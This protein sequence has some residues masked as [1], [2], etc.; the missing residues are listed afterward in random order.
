MNSADSFLDQQDV[1][2]QLSNKADLV[3]GKVP[4]GQLPDS[5]GGG[6]LQTDFN[7]SVVATDNPIIELGGEILNIAQS[8]TDLLKID[9]V[10][11]ATQLG[12]SDGTASAVIQFQG[13]SIGQ[14]RFGLDASVGANDVFINGD[15][16][17]NTIDYSAGT[18]TVT[19]PTLF[20][21]TDGSKDSITISDETETN[22]F[23]RQSPNLLTYGGISIYC[24]NDDVEV[25][26][27]SNFNDGDKQSNIAL[28]SHS[29]F[30]SMVYTSDT[31]TF[32]GKI[33][34]PDIVAKNFA[35][36]A[37]AALGGVELGED[38]HTDGVKKVRI[39]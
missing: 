15:A 6:T 37:A 22:S 32:N 35:D 7:A 10:T 18:Q 4:S 17:A 11:F 13:N 29:G 21:V 25:Y 28:I 24:D 3:D 1:Q 30:T 26:I 20:H 19:A 8:G 23:Q 38:Y 2:Q 12:A 39:V 27:N 34:V 33:I 14:V 5:A 36:D 9:P 16:Q 31:H